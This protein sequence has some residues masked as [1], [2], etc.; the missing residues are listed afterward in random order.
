MFINNKIS[1]VKKLRKILE[2]KNCVIKQVNIV[3]DNK[4]KY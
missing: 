4:F 1:S 2:K 3:Q